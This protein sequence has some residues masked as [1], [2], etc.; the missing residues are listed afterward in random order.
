MMMKIIFDFETDYHQILPYPGPLA[1]DCSLD[2]DL[3]VVL[4][5][6]VLHKPLLPG[7][8]NLQLV[9]FCDLLKS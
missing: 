9:F 3:V 8:L 4:Q 6:T 7:G 5:L 1:R 2:I